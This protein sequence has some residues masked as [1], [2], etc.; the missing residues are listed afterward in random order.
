MSLINWILLIVIVEFGAIVCS[1]LYFAIKKVRQQEKDISILSGENLPYKFNKYTL[2]DSEKEF[3]NILQ[4]LEVIK[5]FY[6]FPQLTLDK[7][8]YIPKET[9]NYWI[10]MNEINRKFVDFTL[11]DK[12]T[13]L[14]QLVIELDGDPHVIDNEVIKR[15][16]FVNSVLS[17]IGIKILYIPRHDNHYDFEN[18]NQK[19]SQSLQ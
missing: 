6:I 13:L 17:S 18:L 9:A 2:N 10:Y 19:I 7:L 16:K 12:T 3:F 5:H 8:I 1:V 4:N 14:P 11:F 15:D